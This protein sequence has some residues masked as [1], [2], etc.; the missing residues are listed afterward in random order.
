[1]NPILIT[2]YTIFPKLIGMVTVLAEEYDPFSACDLSSAEGISGCVVTAAPKWFGVI[3]QIPEVFEEWVSQLIVF[4][5]KVGSIDIFGQTNGTW[6]YPAVGIILEGFQQFSTFLMCI[7]IIVALL[8]LGVAYANGRASV[9]STMGNIVKGIAFNFLCINVMSFAYSTIINTGN[10]LATQIMS[11]SGWQIGAVAGGATT[12]G[13]GVAATLKIITT[14]A[15]GWAAGGVGIVTVIL[16]MGA[17]LFIYVSFIVKLCARAVY[18]LLLQVKGTVYTYNLCRGFTQGV[19]GYI[20]EVLL[21]SYGMIMQVGLM[22]LGVYFLNHSFSASSNTTGLGEFL[23]GCA[24]MVIANKVFGFFGVQGVSGGDGWA[25][26]SS[27]LHM[28]DHLN[29]LVGGGDGG[30][31]A[32][33]ASSVVAAVTGSTPQSRSR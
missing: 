23:L 27:I 14:G 29:N 7:G 12:V 25:K 28:T 9:T 33:G 5:L 19:Q 4:A 24:C 18:Y 10:A 16:I 22:A 2:L 13:T 26:A 1:M 3:P 31:T 21:Y 11:N 17:L 32:S 20:Q 30:S 15:T 8:E 6:D